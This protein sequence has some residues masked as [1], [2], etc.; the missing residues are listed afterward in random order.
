MRK[1]G[2]H[3]TDLPDT[4]DVAGTHDCAS[5][6][7]RRRSEAGSAATSLDRIENNPAKA[8]IAAKEAQKKDR[9]AASED[10][11]AQSVAP[12]TQRLVRSVEAALGKDKR[13]SLLGI[14]VR[15]DSDG[16]IGLHGT[17]PSLQSRTAAESVASLAASPRQ[18]HN[19][20]VVAVR[21]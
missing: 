6:R 16:L 10:P 14:Q 19:Y 9:A 11:P 4:C 13:T 12:E 15:A 5:S 3:E 17:V 7:S 18:V 1:E 8:A 2:S 20:L 21:E